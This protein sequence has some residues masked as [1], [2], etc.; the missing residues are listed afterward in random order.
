MINARRRHACAG[1][2]KDGHFVG[3]KY[4]HEVSC[5][6]LLCIHSFNDISIP[7]MY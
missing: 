3:S 4:F 1:Y 7:S 6:M 2:H 5:F